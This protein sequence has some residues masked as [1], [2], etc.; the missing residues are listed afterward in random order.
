MA[1]VPQ[2]RPPTV[3]PELSRTPVV[4]PPSKGEM[5]APSTPPLTK[6]AKGLID[7]AFAPKIRAPGTHRTYCEN[8][9][10]A[11]VPCT[12]KDKTLWCSYF[13]TNA[14][15][16]DD[17]RQLLRQVY[18]EENKK[19]DG[20]PLVVA[21]KYLA[22]FLVPSPHKPMRLSDFPDDDSGP[23][24]KCGFCTNEHKFKVCPHRATAAREHMHRPPSAFLYTVDAGGMT[25]YR[26]CRATFMSVYAVG[27]D[28]LE[29]IRKYALQ[30]RVTTV[31]TTKQPYTPRD[32]S[33]FNVIDERLKAVIKGHDLVTSHYSS[34]TSTSSTRY[35]LRGDL[36]VFDLWTEYLVAH[37]PEFVEQTRR[38]NFIPS[39]N[40]KLDEPTEAAYRRDSAKKK[41]MPSCSYTYARQYYGRYDVS[42]ESLKTDTCDKCMGLLSVANHGTEEEKVAAKAEHDAHLFEANRCYSEKAKDAAAA[43]LC[44]GVGVESIEIDAATALRTPF[45]TMSA[46]YFTHMQNTNLYIAVIH[47][48]GIELLF[49][50]NETIE[51]KGADMVGSILIHIVMNYIRNP[52]NTLTIWCDGTA[53]QVWNN[54][55]MGLLSEF[56]ER[57][58]PVYCC[59][60]LDLK[61]G[62]VGHTFLNCDK[63]GG[64]VNH[65]ATKYLKSSRSIPGILA[66]FDIANPFPGFC[67]WETIIAKLARHRPTVRC[68]PLQTADFKNV[69]KYIMESAVFAIPTAASCTN[70]SDRWLISNS[71]WW[72][73][74]YGEWTWKE[75]VG[76]RTK[77]HPGQVYTRES[78]DQQDAHIVVIAPVAV[79][80]INADPNDVV[81]A[82]RGR[83]GQMDDSFECKYDGPIEMEWTKRDNIHKL[84]CKML[85]SA[86]LAAR[87]GFPDPGPK[88]ARSAAAAAASAALEPV[89]PAEEGA[90]EL[91]EAD[92]DAPSVGLLAG[93][94]AVRNGSD[95]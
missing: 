39:F 77:W 37:D 24:I 64:W 95:L 87:C 44:K 13:A 74:G 63:I 21:N 54:C 20:H 15:A 52:L 80:T 23:A 9:W 68:V 84:L 47:G 22:S 60:R 55:I 32:R 3:T 28:R 31:L 30:P 65:E 8:A 45:T 76:E 91:L 69:W 42:F 25:P 17:V 56:V 40:R 1:Y 49:L 6:K 57:D 61:R 36:T 50:F 48:L 2:R 86:S 33:T 59:K 43:R 72:N 66:T 51:S 88:P 53:G 4:D 58:S 70:H 90:E 81:R 12:C 93:N 35:F 92:G 41:L 83:R 79:P 46:A 11:F 38:M 10:P 73:F 75:G 29:T 62:P 82:L 27:K 14:E 34:S 78:F 7:P 19:A 85:A 71:R 16:V 67:S 5:D 89:R 26:V 18:D 94:G